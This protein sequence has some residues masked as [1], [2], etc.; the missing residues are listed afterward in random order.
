MRLYVPAKQRRQARGGAEVDVVNDESKVTTRARL[1]SLA[2]FRQAPAYSH[3]SAT[4]NDS[5]IEV[6][7]P[8]SLMYT[9]ASNCLS[10]D[11]STNIGSQRQDH[12]LCLLL[13]LCKFEFELGQKVSRSSRFGPHFRH[14]HAHIKRTTGM[15][16]RQGLPTTCPDSPLS[17]A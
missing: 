9:Y 10:L 11:A 5:L 4:R 8:P 17:H 16:A 12:T 7:I 2:R 14:G 1:T 13:K 15:R 3:Y 6:W